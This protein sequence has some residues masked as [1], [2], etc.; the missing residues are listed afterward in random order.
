MYDP[1]CLPHFDFTE[2]SEDS[3]RTG[4][5]PLSRRRQPE[6]WR[7]TK[8]LVRTGVMMLCIQQG[9]ALTG[10]KSRNR[11]GPPYSVCRP[12]AHAPGPVYVDLYSASS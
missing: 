1:T 11:T 3:I 2:L 8:I 7:A 9:V 6:A 4:D 10:T 5:R 12:T